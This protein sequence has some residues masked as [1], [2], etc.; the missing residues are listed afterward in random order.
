M[1]E[2]EA[3]K[4]GLAPMNNNLSLHINDAPSITQVEFVRFLGIYVDQHFTWNEHVRDKA[5]LNR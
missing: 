2:L 4:F 5:N 1:A 3:I